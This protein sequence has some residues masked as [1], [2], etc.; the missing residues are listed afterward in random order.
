MERRLIAPF[1]FVSV[2]SMPVSITAIR[3]LPGGDWVFL[4]RS[5]DFL[6]SSREL[7]THFSCSRYS[8]A[9]LALESQVSSIAYMRDEDQE[10]YV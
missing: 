7:E 1:I 4:L 10:D 5:R 6:S 3:T 9:S 2:V 8:I